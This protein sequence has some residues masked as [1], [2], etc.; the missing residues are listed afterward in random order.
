MLKASIGFIISRQILQNNSFKR[1]HF[2]HIMK[3][4]A[5]LRYKKIESMAKQSSLVGLFSIAATLII[6]VVLVQ[7]VDKRFTRLI[8]SETKTITIQILRSPF[9]AV[10][11]Q[12]P[13]RPWKSG[14]I[15]S[16][17]NKKMH[18]MFK[19]WRFCVPRAFYE[20]PLKPTPKNRP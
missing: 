16:N 12:K 8:I 18:I 3:F 2:A 5:W 7:I 4:F 1:S 15:E 14:G 19:G 9:Y 13:D 10:T 11:I 20:Q 17:K 6:I